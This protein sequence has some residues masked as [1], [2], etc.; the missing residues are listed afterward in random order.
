MKT[1]VNPDHYYELWKRGG[2][3]ALTETELIV[4]QIIPGINQK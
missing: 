4:T 1:D 2:N 3:Y